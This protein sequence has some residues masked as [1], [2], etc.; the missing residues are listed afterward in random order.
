M[1][2]NKKASDTTNIQGPTNQTDTLNFAH[3]LPASQ[4]LKANDSAFF[5]DL[6]RRLL[7]R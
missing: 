6:S 5:L 7:L 4:D 1:I 3:A 2:L